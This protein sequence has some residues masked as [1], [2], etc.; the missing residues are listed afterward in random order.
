M[1]T[2]S[3]KQPRLRLNYGVQTVK[4]ACACP[5]KMYVLELRQLRW[6]VFFVGGQ[7]HT[8]IKF[9]AVRGFL[10]YACKFLSFDQDKNLHCLPIKDKNILVFPQ[11]STNTNNKSWIGRYSTTLKI[12]TLKI[13]EARSYV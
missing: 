1:D 6:M 5:L 2:E 12:S 13:S 3:R 10:F 7:E 4:R 8:F 9:R 11:R